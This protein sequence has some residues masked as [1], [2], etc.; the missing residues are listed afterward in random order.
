MCRVSL[1]LSEKR[2]F[3]LIIEFYFHIKAPFRWGRGA[4]KTKRSSFGFLRFTQ[5]TLKALGCM[6]V[7]GGKL[8]NYRNRAEL[9]ETQ[10]DC[11]CKVLLQSL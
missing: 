1:L 4:L 7:V 9:Q 6:L 8:I 10:H 11:A 5:K 3:V 2:L